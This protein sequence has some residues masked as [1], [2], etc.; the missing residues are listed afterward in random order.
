MNH[1]KKTIDFL[2][3]RLIIT[4][5]SILLVCVVIQVLARWMGINSTFT[6]E[7][8]RFMFIWVGLFGASLAH[9]QK[10]HLAIDL[11]TS[12]L[13]GNRK[14]ISDITIHILVIIFAVTVMIYGG[15]KAL[16]NT[17]G[18]VSSVMH[19]PMWIIYL[20]IP[21]NGLAISFYSYYDLL[22]IF[23]KKPTTST[24]VDNIMDI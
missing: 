19:I 16:L 8:A 24:E 13:K 4:I 12:K 1:L 17:Q 7:A 6:D 14:R 3:A 20:A 2:L 9:G 23:S 22:V 21:L 10:R 11:L 15:G 18:Q 5:F